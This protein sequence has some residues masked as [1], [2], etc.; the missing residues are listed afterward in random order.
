MKTYNYIKKL[1]VTALST[2]VIL[3]TLAPMTS[4]SAFPWNDSLWQTM[5]K[6]DALLSANNNSRVQAQIDKL[7]K[8]KVT[9]M[10][11]VANAQPYI[12]YIYQQ[13][14]KRGMPAELALLPMVESN[15]YPYAK[16]QCGAEGLWQLMPATAKDRGVQMNWWFDG[17]R[18][19]MSSTNAGLDELERL[20]KLFNGNWLLAIA[21]YNSGEGT[22]HKAIKYNQKHHLP[23]DYWSLKLPKETEQYVPKLLA[24]AAILKN[25]GKYN[26][27]LPNLKNSSQISL[28]SLNKPV[29]LAELANL[30]HMDTDELLRLNPAYLRWVT[31]IN[32]TYSLVV[33]NNKV[34]AVENA[35]PTFTDNNLWY[36]YSV[37]QKD[38]LKSIAVS[39]HVS[40]DT[41]V[42]VNNLQSSH[43]KVGQTL[44]IP[45]DYSGQNNSYA[46]NTH[47]N[48]TLPA[49]GKSH[50][51]GF[52][53]HTITEATNMRLQKQENAIL[54]SEDASHPPAALAAAETQTALPMPQL[55]VHDEKSDETATTVT[56]NQTSDVL[57]NNGNSAQKQDGFL[58]A[59]FH[60]STNAFKRLFSLDA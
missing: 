25:S 39:Y 57:A 15:Y 27:R 14:V 43:V 40:T 13:T 4:S 2:A 3:S 51:G 20:H 49:P 28:I 59:L 41:L 32:G 16:S 60:N 31:P 56:K 1:S 50:E 42:H 54:A 33:P 9:V 35:L 6:Y 47:T 22:V 5:S 21:A 38:S 10:E 46:A 8:D 58:V 37:T 19:F 18:D 12:Y 53:T 44:L 23:T 52:S 45:V 29:N 26:L 48:V 55:T 7:S 17:R 30:T 11:D 36:H 34:K 24:L